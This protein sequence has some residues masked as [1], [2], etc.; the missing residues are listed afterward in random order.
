MN[1][2]KRLQAVANLLSSNDVIA[3]V[4]CDHGYLSIYLIEKKICNHVIAMDVNEG[5]LLC[6][7][8]NIQL[9]NAEDKIELFCSDGLSALTKNIQSMVIAGMGGNLMIKIL[10]DSMDKVINLNEFVLQPQ[11]DIPKVRKFLAN[12]GF[13]IIKEDMVLEDHKFY[14]MFKVQKG[15]IVERDTLFFEYGEYLLKNQHP[16]LKLYLEKEKKTLLNLRGKLQEQGN[17]E[18]R[19][20]E[21]EIQLRKNQ[22]ALEYYGN[23]M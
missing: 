21:V 15:S 23:N 8:K 19:L 16:I 22:R 12:N 1:L 2:S 14:M 3:D 6:A 17:L 9:C 7:K 18:K 4:G 5:P 13:V 20:T 10:E 11:S